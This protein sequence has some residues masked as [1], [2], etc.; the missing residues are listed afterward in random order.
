M[1]LIHEDIEAD[2]REL[3]DMLRAEGRDPASVPISHFD[4]EQTPEDELRRLADMGLFE[5]LIPCCPTEDTDTV[6]RW[7]D[8]YAEIG[9]KLR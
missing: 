9:R 7:L 2:V 6:L 8:R 5:R 1:G 4:V 3:H